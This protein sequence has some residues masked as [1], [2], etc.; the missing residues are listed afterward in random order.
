MVT[1]VEVIMDWRHW[2]STGDCEKVIQGIKSKEPATDAQHEEHVADAIRSHK[3][4]CTKGD[5]CAVGAAHDEWRKSRCQ[6]VRDDVD[7]E[8]EWHLTTPGESI[9]HPSPTYQDVSAVFSTHVDLCPLKE[10]CPA[11]RRVP[12]SGL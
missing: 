12:R 5:S 7:R 6:Q 8:E 4:Q 1:Y 11:W 10:E 9:F 2:I 3:R